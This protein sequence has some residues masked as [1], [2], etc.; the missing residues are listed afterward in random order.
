MYSKD[1]RTLRFVFLG[2]AKF[3]YRPDLALMLI[4]K[5]LEYGLDC[6]ID[7]INK[8]DHGIIE[9]AI[10]LAR[11]PK[12]KIRILSCEHSKIPDILATYDCGLVMVETSNWRRVCSP[13]KTSEYLASGLPVISLK[14]IAALDELSERTECVATVSQEELKGRLQGV[15]VEQIVSFIRSTGVTH[16]CQTLAKVEFDFK[17]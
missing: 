13:T 3:P 6:N 7:F 8:G 2:G 12:E 4:E 11:V 1:N 5:L 9:N 14:G 15:R 16:K 17:V 10:E